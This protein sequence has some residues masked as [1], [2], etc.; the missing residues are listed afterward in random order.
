MHLFTADGFTGQLKECDEG[1]LQWVPKSRLLDLTLW[2]GDK[3]FLELLE[4]DAP[5]FLLKLVYEGDHLVR[6]ILNGEVI[7]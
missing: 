3:I 6:A 1:D 5:F 2:E 7:R 4:Q